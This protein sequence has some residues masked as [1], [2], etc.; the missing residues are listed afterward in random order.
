[1]FIVEHVDASSLYPV[2]ALSLLNYPLINLLF[3]F[4]GIK[5]SLVSTLRDY[6]VGFCPGM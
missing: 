6:R 1:M 4:D 3:G 5:A 2:P